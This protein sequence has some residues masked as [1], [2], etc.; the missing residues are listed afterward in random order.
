MF[1]VK[2]ANIRIHMASLSQLMEIISCAFFLGGK[3]QTHVFSFTK[4]KAI[5]KVLNLSV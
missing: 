5:K 4:A 1:T 3:I 2:H